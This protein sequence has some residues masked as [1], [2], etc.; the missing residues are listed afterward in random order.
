MTGEWSNPSQYTTPTDLTFYH[1]NNDTIGLSAN[2]I[3]HLSGSSESLSSHVGRS[4]QLAHFAVTMWIYRVHSVSAV[5]IL[6]DI[7]KAELALV[8][9]IRLVHVG[10]GLMCCLL[11]T[12]ILSL[13]SFVI[14]RGVEKHGN[15]RTEL[16]E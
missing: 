8:S 3:V 2:E 14:K 12:D 10:H 5:T 13:I 15:E 6:P 1:M 7:T 11:W 9:D 16:F 4:N